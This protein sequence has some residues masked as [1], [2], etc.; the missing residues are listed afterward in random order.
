[1][2]NI[3]SRKL[4]P[5]DFHGSNKVEEAFLKARDQTKKNGSG[6]KSPL[7]MAFDDYHEI[8]VFADTLKDLTGRRWKAKEVGFVNGKYVG[9]FWK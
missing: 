5:D 1:M 6:L 9:K 7:Y 4:N 2:E 8:E 3:I